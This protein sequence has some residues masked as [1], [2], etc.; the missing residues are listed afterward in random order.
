[1]RRWVVAAAVVGVGAG[2]CPDGARAAP[3]PKATCSLYKKTHDGRWFSTID[4]K[5]GNP[6]SFKLLKAG[7][8]IDP[9]MTVVGIN[10]VDT[11]NKLCGGR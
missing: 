10:V 4:S 5:V 11:I 3:E 9:D 1:M 8:A 7:V 6:K 2:A